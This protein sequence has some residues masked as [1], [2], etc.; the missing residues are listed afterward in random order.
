MKKVL[1]VYLPFCTPASPPYS[2]TNLY[3]FLK[4]NCSEQIDAIDLN[5]EFHKLKFPDYQKY[6]Q[7]SAKWGDYDA[8]TNE[9]SKLTAKTYAENNKRV[10]NKE[11][12]EFFDE[13]LKKIEEKKPDIVAFSIVYSSQAFYAY[14]IIKELK[15]VT[16][17]GGP[18]VN[19]RLAKAADKALNN[20]I[21]LLDFIKGKETEH[22]KLNCNTA[23]DFSIYN[24][25]DY[26]TPNPVIPLKTCTSC[27]YRQC[28]FCAHYSRIPYFE[29]SLDLVKETVVNSKQKHFFMIDDMIH[30]KRL[31]KMAEI[32]KPLNLSW[33]VQL[34]PTKELD[35]E[36]LKKLRESGLRF[37]IWGVES[38]N[39]RILGLMKKGTNKA[40][41]EKVLEASHEAGIKNIVYIVFGFPTETKEE[42][43]DTIEFLKRNEKNID[44]ISTSIFG[45]HK[46][47]TIYNNPEQFGVTKVQEEERSVLGPIIKYEVKE[48]LTQEDAR[49]LRGK[50][51]KTLENIN[52]LPKTMNFFREHVFGLE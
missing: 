19:E 1:L 17:I 3:S 8:K 18:A 21:E 2:I 11:K 46:G 37:I 39:D 47:T 12:P 51:K 35:S 36:T 23:P 14:S 20:E 4:N 34:R 48:G 44:L 6:Y 27:Y 42:F 25:N 24:L 49:K 7:D 13:L 31:L 41:V 5:I 29:F 52:K 16:V 43:I 32:F 22:D 38:G 30:T 10:L 33:S 26:F 15:A 45:L 50:Y 9:Y 28:T 40:D